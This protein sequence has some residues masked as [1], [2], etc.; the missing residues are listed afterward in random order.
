MQSDILMEPTSTVLK[1]SADAGFCLDQA[2]LARW[3][4][5]GLLPR[6]IQRPLGKGRGTVSFYPVGTAACLLTIC[7]LRKRHRNLR[8]IGF[9]LW[10]SGYPVADQYSLRYL[11]DTE[12]ELRKTIKEIRNDRK[13][14]DSDDENVSEKAWDEF[15]KICKSQHLPKFMK[16]IRKRVSGEKFDTALRLLIDIVSG[17][18]HGFSDDTDNK[19]M[20][21]MMGF[22]KIKFFPFG[23]FFSS[24]AKKIETALIEL[25]SIM[26]EISRSETMQTISQKELEAARQEFMELFLGLGYFSWVA[27][28][29]SSIVLR[30]K[31]LRSFLFSDMVEL[32]KPRDLAWM[33]IVWCRI[34][35]MPWAQSY[36]ELISTLKKCREEVGRYLEFPEWDIVPLQQLTATQLARTME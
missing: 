33:L 34:R 23:E 15:E 3:H 27:L 13:R 25:S 16:K 36:P 14:L 8:D 21:T 24:L 29:V 6:P 35:Q 1:T 18:F 11:Q 28:R 19:I 7:Q 10:L 32:A 26:G 17:E 30:K 4:R 22:K 31:S 9:R 20:W 2:K 12:F 5:S